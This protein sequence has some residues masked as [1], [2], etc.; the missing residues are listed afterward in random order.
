[1]DNPL[2]K[3]K[4]A[5]M[6]DFKP[7]LL[8][9]ISNVEIP[10]LNQS[11]NK[12]RGRKRKAVRPSVEKK[13]HR[14]RNLELERNSAGSLPPVDRPK[15]FANNQSFHQPNPPS[16]NELF[17][18][19]RTP[20][21]AHCQSRAWAG[22]PKISPAAGVAPPPTHPLPALAQPKLI[23]VNSSRYSNWPFL[24]NL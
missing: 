24:Y 21:P 6:S 5:L 4:G 13:F 20:P 2:I 9:P 22:F 11:R 14:N 3:L 10:L 18:E 19:N 15:S 1:M 8:I 12:E 23:S 17:I 7:Q 16:Y